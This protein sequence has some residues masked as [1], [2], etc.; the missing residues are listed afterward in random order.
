MITDFRWIALFLLIA[1]S[2]ANAQTDS[3][4]LEDTF[5]FSAGL[6]LNNASASIGATRHGN[7]PVDLDLTDLGVDRDDLFFWS[8]FSW[9][10]SERWRWDLTYSA[11]EGNGFIEARRDGNF[12]DV[13]FD[14]GASLTGDL[15]TYLFNYLT[16]S[17]SLC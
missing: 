14:A 15:E 7:E 10:F 2:T 6:L 9:R 11:F 17:D 3:P 8:E 12:G 1:A 5:T 16:E 13:S 4:E